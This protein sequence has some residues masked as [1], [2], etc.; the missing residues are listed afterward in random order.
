MFTRLADGFVQFRG[1]SNA[2]WEIQLLRVQLDGHPP[3]LQRV[4]CR[5]EGSLQVL[6]VLRVSQLDAVT[7]R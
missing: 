5:L 4:K 6:H 2:S 3:S 1:K 7:A